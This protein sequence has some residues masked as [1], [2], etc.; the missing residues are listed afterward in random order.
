MIIVRSPLRVSFF[1]GGT[2]HP[3]HKARAEKEHD[4]AT[5][6]EQSVW[7]QTGVSRAEASQAFAQQTDDR[8]QGKERNR[9]G[10][11]DQQKAA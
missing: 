10:S 5:D 8:Q 2:D 1:G 9:N 3:S 7:A 4:R 6:L 11:R